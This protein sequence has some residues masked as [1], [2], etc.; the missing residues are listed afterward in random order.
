MLWV[1]HPT[2]RCLRRWMRYSVLWDAFNGCSL[3]MSRQRQMT[4]TALR[5][6]KLCC[7]KDDRAMRPM[8][9]WKCSWL[10][11]YALGYYSQHFSWTFV[12]IHPVA[13]RGYLPPGQTSV[14][15]PPPNGVFRN[16]KRYISGVHFQKFSNFSIFFTVNI[17]TIFFTS[18]GAQVSLLDTPLVPPIRSAIDILMVTRM[19]IM[20]WCGLWT[21]H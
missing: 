11:D 10:P 7:C 13:A 14:L 18:K 9:P 1:V 16:L 3:K 21:V 2:C 4:A 20:H 15:P 19:A 6:R 12:P 8:V 17:S 5:T